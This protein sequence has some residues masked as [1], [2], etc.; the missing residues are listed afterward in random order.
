VSF[1]FSA[2]SCAFDSGVLL[3]CVGAVEGGVAATGVD[4]VGVTVTGDT[5]L[6]AS[7]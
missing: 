1:G 7:I 3:A 4:G 5:V 6:M 2:N